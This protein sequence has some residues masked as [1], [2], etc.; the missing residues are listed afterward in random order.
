MLGEEPKNLSGKLLSTYDTNYSLSSVKIIYLRYLSLLESNEEKAFLELEKISNLEMLP[1]SIY[2]DILK[3]LFFIAILKG[4]N[5]FIVEYGDY[6]IDLLSREDS[7]VNYRIHAC[8]RLYKGDKAWAKAIING[9]L[10]SLS[11]FAE[12]GLALT[13][14]RYLLSLMQEM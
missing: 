4:D 11:K 5:E 13:E 10:D 3:E 9:G 1:P 8:Y 12:R 14:K 2:H 7:P 6:V